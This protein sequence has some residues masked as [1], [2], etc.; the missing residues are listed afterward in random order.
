MRLLWLVRVTTDPGGARKKSKSATTVTG[1]AL[2]EIPGPLLADHNASGNKSLLG[3][4]GGGFRVCGK[5]R[6]SYTLHGDTM[7]SF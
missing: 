2:A 1:N 3:V 6:T 4:A 5:K 7:S